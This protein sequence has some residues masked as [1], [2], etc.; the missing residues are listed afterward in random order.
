MMASLHINHTVSDTT[1]K[2]FSIVE[3]LLSLT[4]SKLSD[5]K[6]IN[7]CLNNLNE[8][9][10][11]C[12]NII[13]NDAVLLLVNQ[14]CVT[15]L[16]TETSLIQSACK[17]LYNLTQSN[18]K[19]HGRTFATC[20]RWILEALEFSESLAQV[21]VLIAIKS[22]LHAGYFDDINHYARLL[23]RDKGLLM[24]HLNS[25][26]NAWSEINFYALGCLE[27]IVNKNNSN[28]ISEE[29][30]Y[31]I[32]DI[33]FKNL[34]LLPYSN[35]DKL[36]Y[37][38][39][40]HLCLHILHCIILEKL[41]PNS[42]DIVGEILGVVQAFLFHG[43]KGYTVIKPQ[44]LRPA[45]M[46]LPER[47]H[48]VPKC[49]NLKNYKAKPKKTSAKKTASDTENSTPLEH[50]G[51]SK[52]S[53]DSDTSD[54][55][56]NNTVHIDSKVR[57]GAV[58]LLQTL[59]EI[60]QSR[61][62]FGYWPQIVATGSR[63]DAR[64]LTRSIL[65]EPISKVRQNVLSILT[66]LLIGARPF[67]IHAED[68][69]HT[70]FITF[71]GTV[72]LMVKELHFTLS[73]ILLA[74]KNVTVLTHTLKCTA[75]LVQGT[76][77]ERLKS[78]LATKLARNCRPHIFH[79]DPTVRVAALSI[80]EAFASS[81]PITQE[82]LSILAKQSIGSIELG[83]LQLDTGSISDVGTEEEEIDI[84]DVNNSIDSCNEIKTSKDES[85]CLLIRVCL[86]NI[87]N[88]TIST[89]VRLQ[90]LKLMGRL[91]FN[92]GSLIFP[93]L[94]KVTTILISVMEESE[95]QVILHACRVLEIM[96][97][98]LANIETYHSD[99]I[100]FWNIIFESMI[101]LAQTSQTILREA[102]CDCLGSIN[103]NVFTQLSRQRTILIITI[104]F[105]AVRDEESAV[106][107]AGLR[108][109]GMLVTL[110]A[111]DDDTGFLM[112]LADIVCLALDDK[113]LGVRVKSAWAL[114]NLCDCLSRQKQHEEIEPF[115]LEVL[116]PKLY[117]VSVKAAKDNDKVKCNAVRAIG[118]ILYLCP[119]KHILFDTTLGLNA[120]I[121]C[122][123]LGNDMK[124]RWNAC[125]ALGL[126][127]SH[128]PDAILPS[129][130][131]DEVFPAL[132]TLICDSPNF[133]VRTNAAW[134]LYSCSCYGKYTVMLW[135]SIVLAFENAQHVPSY[136]E[137]P[138]RDALIQQLCLTL[139]RV[140]V[141]TEKSE[142]QN[143]WLEIGDH[144]EEISNVMKQFQETVL[145]EKLGDLIKAKA[146]LEH[147]MKNACCIE[148]QQIAQSL[149]NIF[150]RTNR[151]DNLDAI[152]PTI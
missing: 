68:T 69:D 20:K 94:E 107:A 73:L 90:S 82:I 93:H 111:L 151:Y 41:I 129:S 126:V 67:L 133:K 110:S 142:L 51:I 18:I 26:C 116:L 66:E 22:F 49:K 38:K 27:E 76:P 112:D 52:Y 23:L 71:F 152:T 55:E 6:Q 141:C 37:S 11:R 117:H 143:L 145:P 86:E 21:D 88:K 99:G 92:T 47:I 123:V 30:I 12:L 150:E 33:I 106:R 29:F 39:I 118:S 74:E 87:S 100:L 59:I 34:L 2:F 140:A 16:P 5:K 48:V 1:T 64:V 61:E 137:Y 136:V 78:G 13:N 81:E 15:I 32:K 77:Y 14:L 139:S 35:D 46:N 148:E 138:H 80:F 45:A 62:I 97:S 44:L 24:K 63:N 132:S 70:S 127:L 40:I 4:S 89:P 121:K 103:G 42:S 28:H 144:V 131:K 108:A 56:F 57:L 122:A 101:S 9:D 58:R 91:A 113:N 36:Y 130:W 50:T 43:I 8:L 72:C 135:K 120:L 109:L 10:Y 84:G 79:K 104:L 96:S 147:L 128:N 25:P 124:V 114:A 83:R 115:S 102:A 60:S 85:I 134:A 149:A 119:Q 7:A 146:Q 105:G 65:V 98:C 95:S 19:L 17:F 53:S 54:T 125:R 75:A 31:L 3:R